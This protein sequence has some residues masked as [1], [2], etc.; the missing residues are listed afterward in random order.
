[1]TG[2]LIRF[3]LLVCVS[4]LAACGTIATPVWETE[5]AVVS[6]ELAEGEAEAEVTEI[7]VEPTQVEPTEV[8]PTETP[9]PPTATPL[10]PT[11]TEVP[12][13]VPPTAEATEVAT[14][15][16]EQT[17][18]G[19]E[20]GA[21][22]NPEDIGDPEAGAALFVTG[23]VGVGATACN[24]CHFADQEM[25]LVGPG[26]LGLPERAGNRVPG[27]DAVTYIRESIVNPNAYV[28]EGFFESVMP[29]TYGQ[30]LSEEQ[31]N[32]LVAYLLTLHA[33]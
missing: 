20:E 30:V 6:D 18:E 22:V 29:Q 11:A 23:D 12:P 4:L 17:A 16:V 1:M 32:N 21:A 27:K 10:P 5:E 24:T 7:A 33:E 13:T 14:E 25:A 15:A 8:P 3:L 9:L 28:V 26:L 31:I 2:K 19:G